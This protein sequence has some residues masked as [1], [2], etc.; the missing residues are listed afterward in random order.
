MRYNSISVLCEVIVLELKWMGRYRGVV[1]QLIRYCNVYAGVYKKETL[2]P[3][4][5]V[6]VS[7]SQVQ[8]L[9]YLLE[10]EELN[11]NM[12]TI[13][14]RLGITLSSFSK[15]I[16]VLMEK[17]LVE[18]W[19]DFNRYLVQR[20]VQ[21]SIRVGVYRIEKGADYQTIADHITSQ[22]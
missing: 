2:Y 15:M 7:Y 22:Q 5:N 19:S 18:N 20:G 13:A 8:V 10:N 6:A 9:E 21:S 17:G 3:K 1:E 12:S 14:K 16:N 4:T 11:Q